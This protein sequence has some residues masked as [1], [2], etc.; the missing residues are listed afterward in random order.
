M[1]RIIG[2]FLMFS[3]L[4]TVIVPIKAVETQELQDKVW[5]SFEKMSEIELFEIT[6]DRESYD[7]SVAIRFSY[8]DMDFS[9]IEIL[10]KTERR[11]AVKAY[12]KTQNEDIVQDFDL[13]EPVGWWYLT[14]RGSTFP[15]VSETFPC[16]VMSHPRQR[17][18]AAKNF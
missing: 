2:L 17:P 15:S 12:Y 6:A 1:K 14:A 8:D 13:L 7:I 3:L 4:F 10:E 5:V 16:R 11:S 9:E 18:V